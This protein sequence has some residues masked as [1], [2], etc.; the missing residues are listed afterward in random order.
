M[1]RIWLW[2]WPWDGWVERE[3]EDLVVDDVARKADGKIALF[4][5]HDSLPTPSVSR[6]LLCPGRSTRC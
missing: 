4:R 5:C 3:R 6:N 1:L 2:L